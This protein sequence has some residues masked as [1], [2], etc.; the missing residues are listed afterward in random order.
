MPKPTLGMPAIFIV[1]GLLFFASS[2]SALTSKWKHLQ[3]GL[4]YIDL[5]ASRLQP[6]SHIHV[7]RIDPHLYQFQLSLARSIGKEHASVM[8]L[9]KKNHALLAFNGGFFD[10][11]YKPLGLR[12]SS[13]KQLNPKKRIS[14]WGVFAIRHN[15][16]FIAN[17]RQRLRKGYTDFALQS[18]PRLIIQGKIPSLKPGR[19]QRTAMGIDHRGKIIVLVTEKHSMGLEELAQQM[20]K[21][22]LQCKNALNLDGGSSTQLMLN[23]PLLKLNV[24]GFSNVSDIVTVQAR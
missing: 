15:K 18:G 17:P 24:H 20:Q 4:E 16:A 13:G 19:A 7:F 21:K 2:A 8:Q 22:P 11:H 1:I 5:Q 23:T 10:E 3:P 9:A 12:I 6:W 14:W